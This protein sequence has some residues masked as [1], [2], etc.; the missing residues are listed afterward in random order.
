MCLESWNIGSRGKSCVRVEGYFK[1]A[2]AITDTT[3]DAACDLVMD[4]VSYE[5]KI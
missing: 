4:Y 3:N 2:K 5:V 1:R